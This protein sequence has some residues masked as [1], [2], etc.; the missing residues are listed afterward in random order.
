M[1]NTIETP[2]YYA[3]IPANVRYDKKLKPNEKLLYGEIV[4]L[5]GKT[6]E[7]WATNRYFS[8]LY[9]VTI[10]VVSKWISNLSKNGYIRV[11]TIKKQ[12]NEIEKRVIKIV[13]AIETTTQ[14]IVEEKKKDDN[15]ANDFEKLWQIYPRKNGKNNA[16][17]HYKSWIKGKEYAGKKQKLTNEEMW[18]AIR[19]YQC[20]IKKN[21]TD[22][23]YIKMG[24]TFFNEAI[25]EYANYYRSNPEGWKVKIKEILE[26]E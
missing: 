10:P 15:L 17:L 7:C 25:Y 1:D 14:V 16:F 26:S 13:N 23:Q 5:T 21:N 4:A 20:D 6:G 19:I 18:Y 22:K 3:I 24:S 12:N 9:D 2:N 8:Q 11:E